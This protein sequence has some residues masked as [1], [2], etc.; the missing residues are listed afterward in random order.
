M[1]DD[2]LCWTPAVD[3]A[4]AIRDRK[5]SPVAVTQAVLDRIERVNPAINAYCTVVAERAMAEA[6]A[7]EAALTRG[8]PARAAPRRAHVLQGPH[9]DCRHPHD[10]RLEDPRAQCAHRRRRSRRARPARRR[11]RP[12]QDQHAGVRL[13]GRHR[14][15][16]LRAHA[17][18]LERST[19]WRAAPAAA[20]PRRSRP[21]SAPSPRA[22]TSVAPSAC[23]R[24]RAASSASSRPWAACPAIPPRTAGR[25]SRVRGRWRAR[26]A[27]PRCS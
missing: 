14:Q 17:Q 22:A 18:P 21:D 9:G 6:R 11:D 20:R 24:A 5:V 4:A 23:R 19:A 12:R 7:A 1:R 16:G 3:L 2:E 8:E 10:V 15:P 27:T 13:Q 25:R 26:C